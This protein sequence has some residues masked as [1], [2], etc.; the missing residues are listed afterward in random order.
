M[1]IYDWLF[2]DLKITELL[3]LKKCIL[4][5]FL[6]FLGFIKFSSETLLH[7]LFF[8]MLPVFSLP[9]GRCGPSAAASPGSLWDIQSLG[10]EK[11][12]AT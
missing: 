6:S 12:E 7:K 9:K 8:L 11:G 10:S 4:M 3:F 5:D 2:Q 1:P